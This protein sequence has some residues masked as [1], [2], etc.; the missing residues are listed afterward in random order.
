MCVY[1]R[2]LNE[3]IWI[4]SHPL[5]HINEMITRVKDAQYFSSKGPSSAYHQVQLHPESKHLT[6]FIM[7]EGAFQFVRMPFRMASAS[8]IFQRVMRGVLKGI[9]NMLVFQDDILVS[10][11][12]VEF[13]KHVLGVLLSK[14]QG[15]GWMVS[16]DKCK[17][18][19][20]QVEYLGHIRRR[21]ETQ[22]EVSQGYRMCLKTTHMVL[23]PILN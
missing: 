10:G 2:D 7:P 20:T 14:L 1:L 5:P 18:G 19:V 17:F 16:M 13:Y 6:I 4:D 9:T 22:D 21:G 23:F 8:A 11:A 12:D 15:A 3:N